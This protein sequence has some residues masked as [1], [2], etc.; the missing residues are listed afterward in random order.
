MAIGATLALLA[1]LVGGWFLFAD[2]ASPTT[3]ATPPTPAQPQ[4]AAVP[5]QPSGKPAEIGALSQAEMRDAADKITVEAA[6]IHVIACGGGSTPG[7]YVY[8]Y[9]NRRGFRAV[10]PPNWGTALGGKDFATLAEAIGAGCAAAP[11]SGTVLGPP[12]DGF[13]LGGGDILRYYGSPSESACRADC[14]RDAANC[15]AY[16]WVKPEGYVKGDPPVCYL[17]ASYRDPVRHKCCVTATRGPF[18]VK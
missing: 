10:Q 7:I 3:A 11:A 9:V 13:A 5:A 6:T 8:E 12:Y 1:L 17:M 4:Q 15:R 14:E 2:R 18:P 16:T